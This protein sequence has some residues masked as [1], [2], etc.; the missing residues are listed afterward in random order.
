LHPNF[1]PPAH[2]SKPVTCAQLAPSAQFRTWYISNWLMAVKR[3]N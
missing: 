2:L 1:S 3:L